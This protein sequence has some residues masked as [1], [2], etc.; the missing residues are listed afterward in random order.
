[1][2][3]VIGLIVL[4][5]LGAASASTEETV[6]EESL[7]AVELADSV[8]ALLRSVLDSCAARLDELSL[9]VRENPTSIQRGSRPV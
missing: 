4:S 6:A 5:A 7:P 9:A 1:L 2:L 3:V 8:A